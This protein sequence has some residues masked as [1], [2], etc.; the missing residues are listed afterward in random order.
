MWVHLPFLIQT[1]VDAS[2]A[3]VQSLPVRRLIAAHWQIPSASLKEGSPNAG[4][5][6]IHYSGENFQAVRQHKQP[7]VKKICSFT[8][9]LMERFQP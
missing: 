9:V 5:P 7:P 1:K 4:T 6:G 8:A 3:G 2:Q